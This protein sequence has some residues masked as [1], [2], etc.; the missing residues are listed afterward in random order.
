LQEVRVVGVHVRHHR[1]PF[2]LVLEDLEVVAE[3]EGPVL[4]EELVLGGQ[5]APDP[6]RRLVEGCPAGEA[7]RGDQQRRED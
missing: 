2:E 6:L 7:Y 4:G 3:R 1:E 5:L